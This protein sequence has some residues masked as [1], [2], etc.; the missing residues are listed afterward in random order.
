MTFLVGGSMD[1]LS[2]S[3]SIQDVYK[4]LG[5]TVP[6]IIKMKVKITRNY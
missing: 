2:Q 1:M 4:T 3:Q 5:V 6:R